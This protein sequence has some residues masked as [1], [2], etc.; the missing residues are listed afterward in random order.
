MYFKNPQTAICN[1]SWKTTQTSHGKQL[2]LSSSLGKTCLL[3]TKPAKSSLACSKMC[4]SPAHMLVE[5]GAG[6][7][8]PLYLLYSSLA[9]S[10]TS[11]FEPRIVLL[12]SSKKLK[13]DVTTFPAT[14]VG[15]NCLH[16][17]VLLKV[18]RRIPPIW[19]RIDWTRT[20]SGMPNILIES[21]KHSTPAKGWK[22][23]TCFA[24]T[25]FPCM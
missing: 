10:A 19:G 13:T 2:Q 15:K 4:P 1:F 24:V 17:I 9:S 5:V 7:T 6:L 3:R 20:D 16:G 8:T 11:M 25:I 18:I 21:N 12:L 14:V 23:G 22:K